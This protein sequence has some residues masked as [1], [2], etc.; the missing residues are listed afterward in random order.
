M[1]EYRERPE[2]L[3]EK[4]EEK[5]HWIQIKTCFQKTRSNR[6]VEYSFIRVHNNKELRITL[7]LRM[8]NWCAKVLISLCLGSILSVCW[9]AL[10]TWCKE[11]THWK[12]N[13][14][15]KRLRTGGEGA[16]VGEMVGWHHQLNG[17]GREQAP[18]DSEGQGG[19]EWCGP[20]GHKEMDMTEWPNNKNKKEF[21]YRK[22]LSCCLFLFVLQVD[23]PISNGYFTQNCIP[24]IF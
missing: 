19:L 13:W 18:G 22:T 12:I 21:Q 24:L 11:P 7:E 8:Q 9:C 2:K 20:W 14:C 3:E 15:W 10:A 16:S 1:W 23:N 5:C 17:H 4:N 6:N